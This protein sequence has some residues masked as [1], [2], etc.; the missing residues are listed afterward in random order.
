MIKMSKIDIEAEKARA[1]LRE[2]MKG[3]LNFLKKG[4]YDNDSID[5]K[6]ETQQMEIIE[7]LSS[8][9]LPS[10]KNSGSETLLG[11]VLSGSETLL[12]SETIPKNTVKFAE[13][14]SSE[15]LLSSETLP[16]KT[17]LNGEN[18]Q[19]T[20]SET[21]LSSET[22]LT[23]NPFG[24][25]IN[26][27]FLIPM[28]DIGIYNLASGSTYTASIIY[29]WLLTTQKSNIL[30]TSYDEVESFLKIPRSRISRAF[31]RFR[32][33]DLFE[34]KATRQ[35]I[36]IDA[37]K[38]YDMVKKTAV[39]NFSSETLPYEVISWSIP[40]LDLQI[41]C[42][43]ICFFNFSENDI[44]KKVIQ[45]MA[46]LYNKQSNYKFEKIIYNLKYVAD[47]KQIKSKLVYLLRA[48]QE[49]YGSTGL[50]IA[51]TQQ[52]DNQIKAFRSLRNRCVNDLGVDERRVLLSVTWKPLPKELGEK[53]VKQ[54]RT[55]F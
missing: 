51:A 21:L 16:S 35:G 13:I 40:D 24:Q 34:V 53:I 42:D 38:I 55:I 5:V 10:T 6:K 2:R 45:R 30:N 15:T 19:N 31:N 28:L 9:T 1:Q 47:G 37:T 29:Y 18:P 3:T 12:S 14:T 25:T 23:N 22:L 32:E 54:L 36:F 41:L 48:L 17:L 4:S 27:D 46:E 7:N 39:D 20:G 33:S 26:D 44:S 52:V 8:E 43:M 11:S 49:D 50:S